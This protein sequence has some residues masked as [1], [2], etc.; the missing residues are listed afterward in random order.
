VNK[1]ISYPFEAIFTVAYLGNLVPV[2][3]LQSRIPDNLTTYPQVFPQ[4][5]WKSSLDGIAKATDNMAIMQLKL[6]I[7]AR[8]HNTNNSATR[9][10]IFA[11]CN[12]CGGTHDMAVSVLLKDGPLERQSIG[13]VYKDRNLPE[14]L[15]KLSSKNVTC[16][17]T[18]R[19]S[20]QKDN[21]QIFLVP[22]KN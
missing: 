8:L 19:G 20:I 1:I 9:Y 17:A 2:F 3:F 15:A 16:P 12:K 6:D 14:S 21:H 18:G 7:T 13:H 4:F 5:L 11:L 10:S 22:A